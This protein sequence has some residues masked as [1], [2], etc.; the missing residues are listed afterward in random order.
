MDKMSGFV[1]QSAKKAG[2]PTRISHS[3]NTS[4]EGG[5]G[6]RRHTNPCREIYITLCNL[7]YLHVLTLLAKWLFVNK[8]R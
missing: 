3:H 1:L 8:V 4:S 5:S 6:W 2:I 7:I